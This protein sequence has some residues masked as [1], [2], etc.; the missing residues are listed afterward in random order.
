M[1]FRYKIMQFMSGRY[2][3][4]DLFY[5]LF[6]SAVILSVV[7]IVLRSA[8][9]QL[10][11]YAVMIYAIFRVMSRNAEARRR[12]NQSFR[13]LRDKIINKRNLHRQHKADYMHIYK[14]CPR[15]HAVLRLP[16]RK[17]KH[18]TVCPRCNKEFRVYVFKA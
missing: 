16:R 2:G 7:N 1:R 17:G 14:K 12:E 3:V 18:T 15:C 13:K 9:L 10:L 6:A 5:V 11:I 8:V 4:D